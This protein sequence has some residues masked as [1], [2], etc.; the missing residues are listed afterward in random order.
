MSDIGSTIEEFIEDTVTDA[1][2]DMDISYTVETAIDNVLDDKVEEYVKY[3][4]DVVQSADFAGHL[5]D[6]LRDPDL[7]LN[8]IEAFQMGV[9]RLQD[10]IEDLKTGNREKMQM[11][12]D[13]RANVADLREQ[14]TNNPPIRVVVDNSSAPDPETEANSGQCPQ[15]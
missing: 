15:L 8:L 1:V 2:S 7:L 11:I 6:N 10:R 5:A 3:E 13:L 12:D 14:L 4:A 9:G